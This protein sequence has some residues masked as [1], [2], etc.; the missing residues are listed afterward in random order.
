V[1]DP[2]KWRTTPR[3]EK[4]LLARHMGLKEPRC[5]SFPRLTAPSH[6]LHHL[7]RNSNHEQP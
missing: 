2:R 7:F 3:A 6:L 1:C 5:Q 4:P